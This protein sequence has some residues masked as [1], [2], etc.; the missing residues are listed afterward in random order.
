MNGAPAMRIEI[1]CTGNGVQG[2]GTANHEKC[3]NLGVHLLHRVEKD[4]KR[5]GAKIAYL[6]SVPD[7]VRFYRRT[8]FQVTT[9]PC[10]SQATERAKVN[11]RKKEVFDKW[12]D[13][14]FS[15]P[16]SMTNQK[17]RSLAS[18]GGKKVSGHLVWMSKCLRD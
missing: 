12:L 11:V 5:L 10:K 15:M 1:L 2:N 17:L 13:H 4:A 18:F 14:Y 9:F 6:Q 7:A 16:D 8:G 3:L